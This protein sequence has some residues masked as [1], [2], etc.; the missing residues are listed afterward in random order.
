MYDCFEGI[1]YLQPSLEPLDLKFFICKNVNVSIAVINRNGTSNFTDS[2]TVF[3]Y[4]G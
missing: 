3:V 2:V 4:G 1:L